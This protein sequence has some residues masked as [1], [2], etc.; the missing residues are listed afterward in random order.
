MSDTTNKRELQKL[1][2]WQQNLNRSLKGQLY[3]LQS[4][5]DDN[6][7]IVTLQE[8]HIDFLGRTR[9]NP[10]WTVIYPKRHLADPN[11]TRSIILMNW[12]ISTNKWAE[13]WLD[14][15]DVTGVRLHGDFRVICLLNI[16][17]N[18]ENNRSIEEV[19]RWMRVRGTRLALSCCKRGNW[20]GSWCW[21]R[22]VEGDSVRR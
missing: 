20:G 13:I 1:R 19:K 12:R 3:L 5:K 2:I 14:S 6:Y 18:C 8:P 11:K 16:Y 10:H 15:M 9:A 17:N 22:C 4:L 21:S 7:D